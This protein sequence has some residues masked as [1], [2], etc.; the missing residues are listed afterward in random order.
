MAE[1]GA[2]FS[3][4]TFCILHTNAI[5]RKCSPPILSTYC[6]VYETKNIKSFG[7]TATFKQPDH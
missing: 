7:I 5:N 2:V 3:Y 4:K 6:T 1:T